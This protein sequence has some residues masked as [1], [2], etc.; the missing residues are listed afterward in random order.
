MLKAG[1]SKI[2]ITPEIGARGVLLAQQT[3]GIPRQRALVTIQRRQH[4]LPLLG[5]SGC[6]LCRPRM[7]RVYLDN[8]PAGNL[9]LLQD[10][11]RQGGTVLWVL[12][13]TSTIDS[14]S[15]L[16]NATDLT[17]EQKGE[18]VASDIGNEVAERHVASG[19]NRVARV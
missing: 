3:Q 11:V 17:A 15:R 12:R 5:T 6:H 7:G 13:D 18:R 14:L 10:R 19:G 16:V 4:P 9:G 1:W 8:V 2:A